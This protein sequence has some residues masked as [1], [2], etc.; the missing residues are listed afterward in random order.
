VQATA[1]TAVAKLAEE[2]R[3]QVADLHDDVLSANP[4]PVRGLR[5][6]TGWM[7]GLATSLSRGARGYAG[8]R[9][10]DMVYL[11]LERDLLRGSWEPRPDRG[12]DGHLPPVPVQELSESRGYARGWHCG[13]QWITLWLTGPCA[14]AYAE[15]SDHGRLADADAVRAVITSPRPLSA[16]E[17]LKW[18]D[19]LRSAPEVPFDASKG[20]VF[21]HLQA[22]GWSAVGENRCDEHGDAAAAGPGVCWVWECSS[23][24]DLRFRVWCTGAD[25]VGVR[26]WAGPVV[27]MAHLVQITGA[28]R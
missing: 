8:A 12:L 19:E 6:V 23:D 21:T 17:L 2:L 7:D 22:S 5:D 28:H 14:F 16:A 25:I 27:D 26:Y 4:M 20:R 1:L 18:A 10:S 9:S 13:P 15:S 3:C 24:V 11:E